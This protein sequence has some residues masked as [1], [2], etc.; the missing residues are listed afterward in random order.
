MMF[1]ALAAMFCLFGGAAQAIS[2]GVYQGGM[3]EGDAAAANAVSEKLSGFGATVILINSAQLCDPAFFAASPIDILLLPDAANLP[4]QSVASISDYL[5]NGGNII[6]LNAPLW[7]NLF[8]KIADKWRTLED[9]ELESAPQPPEHAFF[10]FT[11][12]EIATW[13][14]GVFPPEAV[15]KYESVD[16]APTQGAHSLHV[17]MDEMKGWDTFA[18]PTLDKPFPDEMTL[19]VFAAK[20]NQNT[21]SLS[22]EWD[23]KDGSRWIAVVPLSQQWRRYTLRPEDFKFWE[24]VPARAADRFHPENAVSVHIGLAQSHTNCPAGPKE[25]WV[26]G[27]GASKLTPEME[28]AFLRPIIPKFE[29]LSP[30]YKF[31]ETRD[32]AKLVTSTDQAVLPLGE[33]AAPEV[34]GSVHPRPSGGGFDKGRLWRWIPLLEAR[35]DN[36]QWRGVPASIMAHFDGPHKGG[37]W[38][39][40]AIEDPQWRLSPEALD[41][42]CA[43]IRKMDE[44]VYLVD[45]GSDFY[46][47]FPGQDLTLGVHAA[48]IGGS[49]AKDLTARVIVTNADSGAEIFRKEWPLSLAAGKEA[50]VKET[51]KPGEWPKAGFHV[52]AELAQGDRVIDRV[53]NDANVWTP[54]E[55]KSFITT[56][57]GDFK[58]NGKRWRMNGVNY[59]PSSG[60]AAENDQYFEKWLS[61][62]SYDPKIIQRDLDHV[63]DLGLNAVSI[64]IYEDSIE[65]QNLLDILRRL[66]SMGLKVNLSLRPGTIGDFNWPQLREIVEYYRLW[67]QDCIFAYDMDWEPLWKAHSDRVKWD[68]AWEEWVVERYGSMENAERDWGFKA[69]RNADGAVTNPEDGQLQKDGDWRVMAAAYRRFLDTLLY[70]QYGAL[71]ED[72]RALDPFHH[73]SFRMTEAGDPT[74]QWGS[75]L[76]YDFPYLASA[77]DILEPEGYGRLGDWEKIKPACFEYV[78]GRW[79]APD[80]PFI[81]AEAGIHTWDVASG[82][83]TESSLATQGQFCR[84]YYKAVIDSGADGIVWW[85]YPGG[86]R[87]GENSDYGIVNPDGTDRPS[88]KAIRENSEAFLNGPDAKPIDEWMEFDRDAHTDG[89]VGAYSELKD[90][91]W[92]FIEEGRSPGLRTKGTGTT[93]ADCPL[94]AVGNTQCNGSNPP[95]YLDGAFDKVEIQDRGG[96]WTTVE[97]NGSVEV[98]GDKPVLARVTF[99]NLGEASWL[100]EGPG[101]VRI[102]LTG[103]D[104][105]ATRLRSIVANKGVVRAT[106]VA[107]TVSA[108]KEAKEIV[109]GFDAEGRTPFGEKFHVKLIPS[110]S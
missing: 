53:I 105:P 31:F 102:I 84:D 35:S 89:I 3:V 9:Y 12:E 43:V 68:R 109:L 76:P 70:K 30:G 27:F 10:Q 95:K 19:T 108:F 41:A 90:A 56:E 79:A 45:G 110:G 16:E 59:M 2:V 61:A 24:S 100:Y 51:C 21:T 22:V 92:K 14:R 85:W 58:L 103:S 91:Y 50:T 5:K 32:A 44:G 94:L 29:I 54:K 4:A 33:F 86:F 34:T 11:D 8:V 93:S 1:I 55:K 106:S 46:T 7:K 28:Q 73:V 72:V 82:K 78:Y 47:Y 64:F 77:V 15:A 97:K 42:V 62:A 107:L 104:A 13:T 83:S 80:L 98:R 81:W 36:G 23:E 6:A 69:P 67:E 87:C 37:Q 101:A 39:S 38:A 17:A 18:S 57:N 52:T 74:M 71:R 26:S 88:S 63:K 99:T 48:N 20:G 60:I 66:D 49:S 65:A 75:I 40:F 25:Y 96:A